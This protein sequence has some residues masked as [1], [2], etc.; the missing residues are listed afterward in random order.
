[1]KQRTS[2][3]FS[4][5]DNSKEEKLCQQ[6]I[7]KATLIEA[8]ECDAN[9]LPYKCAGITRDALWQLWGIDP[10]RRFSY[11]RRRLSLD[12]QETVFL[13]ELDL[14]LGLALA[15]FQGDTAEK[16]CEAMYAY[17]HPIMYVPK[18][19]FTSTA[20]YLYACYRVIRLIYVN[21]SVSDSDD[22]MTREKK[23]AERLIEALEYI[24]N[25]ENG[26]Q[27]LYHYFF[28]RTL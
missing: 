2:S 25:E 28:G 8:L 13:E 5:T 24:Q 21:L 22:W 20:G 18:K 7:R 12:N 15:L 14:K 1:M 19:Y 17:G 10:R 3:V 27:D 9:R 4:R 6:C 11:Y 26:E 23:R 16:A